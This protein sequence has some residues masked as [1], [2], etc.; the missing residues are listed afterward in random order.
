[1]AP[2]HRGRWPAL[3]SN[4]TTGGTSG[5]LGFDSRHPEPP[6]AQVNADAERLGNLSR[7]QSQR[8]VADKGGPRNKKRAS[9]PICFLFLGWIVVGEEQGAPS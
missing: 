6:I 3:G 4:S 9:K 1:M 5:R 7:S 8:S 2:R